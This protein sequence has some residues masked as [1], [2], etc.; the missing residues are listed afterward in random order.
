[1]SENFVGFA[2]SPKADPRRKLTK[3]KF[4]V[5][6]PRDLKEVLGSFATAELYSQL[7]DKS[8]RFDFRPGG[9]LVFEGEQEYRGTFSQIAIPRSIVINTELHGE[10]SFS[11]RALKTGSRV[12]VSVRRAVLPEES[13]KWELACQ[14]LE[15]NLLEVFS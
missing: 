2:Q 1:M 10:A 6:L 12:T 4:E 5:E 15:K 9:K 7:L 8:T 11:F 14:K 3:K 13:E